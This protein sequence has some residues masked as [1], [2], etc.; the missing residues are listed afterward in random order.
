M[1]KI[2]F[3]LLIIMMLG[4]KA[5]ALDY[6]WVGGSGNWSD[7][8]HH[9]A[10]S[11]G[12]NTFHIQVPQTIDNVFF[13]ANSFSAANQSVTLDQTVVHCADMDWTGAQ[14]N[15]KFT[16]TSANILFI[17]GSLRFI[18]N[19]DISSL[20]CAVYF[21]ATLLGKTI[22][23][24][25]QAFQG[26]VYLD[27]VGGGWSLLDD[28][29]GS[30]FQVNQGTF[31][32]LNHMLNLDVF[33]YQNAVHISLGSS[34][35][36]ISLE[37]EA[38]T[39]PASVLDA[40]T[41]T[42]NINNPVVEQFYGG[43]ANYYDVNFINA[44][45]L[46]YIQEEGKN[47]SFHDV[48]FSGP[49]N[50]YGS[51]TFHNL[52]FTPGKT[53][54]L[55]AANTQTI[56]NN[57]KA[58]APCDSVIIISSSIVGTQTSIRKNGGTGITTDYTSLKDINVFGGAV[59]TANDVT[60]RGNNTGWKLNGP[61][62][63]NLYWVGGTGIW[64]DPS[65][66]SLS[67]GGAGGACIPSPY[68]NVYF[69][70][71]SFTS[72]NQ[73]V[74]IDNTA[75]CADMDWTGAQYK[76]ALA[77]VLGAEGLLIY[78]SLRFINNMDISALRCAVYFEATSLG[79]TI[80][81][82]GQ[83]FPGIVY[84]DGVNGGWSLLDDFSGSSFQVNQGT[85]ATL[86][87]M[88]NLSIFSYQNAVHISLG[89]SIINI[90]LVWEGYTIPASVLDAGTSTININTIAPSYAEFYGGFANYY[91]VNFTDTNNTGYI[92]EE[93]KDISFYDVSFSGAGNING[94]Y[95]FNNLTLSAGQYYTFESSSTQTIL[96][97]LFS[98]GTGGFPIRIQASMVNVP[99]TFYKARGTVCLN[100][101][102]LSDNIATGGA[103]FYANSNSEDISGNSGW[104]FN[105]LTSTLSLPDINICNNDTVPVIAPVGYSIYTWLPDYNISATT[106]DTIQ[107]W[108]STDTAY[109]LNA[110]NGTACGASG[111]FNV[112][113]Y[114]STPIMLGNDTSLCENNSIQ[115][116]AG[117][118]FNNYTWNNG[119][120]TQSIT[121][122]APGS[123]SVIATDVNSC[124]SK[125]TI[126]ILQVYALPVIHLG[127]DTGICQGSGLPLDA[128]SGFSK[129][130]WQDSSS[131]QYF[132]ATKAGLYW[133]EVTNSNSCK[134]RDSLNITSVTSGLNINI[135]KDTVL[136]EGEK[137]S[138]DATTL[139][140]TGYLWNDN[141]INP[142]Y[143][144]DNAGT[145]WVQVTAGGC[146]G[147]DTIT[148]NYKTCDCSLSPMKGFTPNNDG[149]N[150][151][152]I[153]FKP[154]CIKYALVNIYNRWGGLV[155]HSDS[156][157]NDWD[158]KYKGNPV[159]DGTYYYVIAATYNDG[160]VH[161]L[162][163]NV[164]IIR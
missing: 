108:P 1:K 79:K 10:T 133:V 163:G 100:F 148:V 55:E 66:W 68:D 19:M 98:T 97:N 8:A 42:I 46:G 84:L 64:S 161:E 104:I 5:Y 18:N 140:A 125:D 25:E 150:D 31:A 114:K 52:I 135:G 99:F 20:L 139:N 4:T 122:S 21:E 49:G 103:K 153:V 45:T 29:S 44:N 94:S 116:N 121:V 48:S 113:V 59:F 65:H 22:M 30:F 162:T 58:I 82:A 143:N 14:Y 123:Y 11:S 146:T 26:E 62:P 134:A 81:T 87:H 149:H 33:A 80:T 41:S 9:W 130:L 124:K 85:F 75:T 57:L 69:D 54:L 105:S 13:D 3:V 136:C 93:G 101:L 67:S 129:Y 77:S 142:I 37:W 56:T 160:H 16:T 76:P 89:S 126:A 28:F 35:I 96:G 95:T 159:T 132:T 111:S 73:T 147:A 40:G 51:N 50:I 157:N 109:T 138:L 34:V 61:A 15:P 127:N 24:A 71:N 91:D 137:L 110:G 47:I 23:S 119:A 7:Y 90:A 88:V 151:V 2:N 86:N 12:G 70:A 39:I 118:G 115:L 6:Y 53:Y 107:I 154:G 63:R 83:V 120:N 152:W 158:G 72:S 141:S 74:S 17:Y 131:G 27:G 155:Y 32:T 38:F 164:T 144:V 43:F 117:T 112:H 156:Y 102:R 106:G 60:D 128:G 92:Q 78:G 145:Y 36:N